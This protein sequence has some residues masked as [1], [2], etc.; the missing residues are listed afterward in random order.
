[1]VINHLLNG[2]IL[3][4]P[5]DSQELLQIV[6]WAWRC[7]RWT[8][9]HKRSFAGAQGCLDLLGAQ[10]AWEMFFFLFFRMDS[11][12]IFFIPKYMIIIWSNL[13]SCLILIFL[14]GCAKCQKVRKLEW[15]KYG[16]FMSFALNT[17][18]IA[19]CTAFGVFL[20]YPTTSKGPTSHP[21]GRRGTTTSSMR[22]S[23]LSSRSTG[24]F[25]VSSGTWTVT[26]Q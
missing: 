18:N 21:Q 14:D 15:F 9:C 12:W 1:M 4:V 7:L 6:P 10:T 19:I 3:Q 26:S 20:F 13:G 22:R 25:R 2:M 8:P 16:I 23:C 5:W 17:R 11:G 24:I